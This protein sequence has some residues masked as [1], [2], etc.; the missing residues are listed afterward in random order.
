MVT[1]SGL[2]TGGKKP[3]L[4]FVNGLTELTSHEVQFCYHLSFPQDIDCRQQWPFFKKRAGKIVK[5]S[6]FFL[7]WRATLSQG[8]LINTFLSDGIVS[9]KNF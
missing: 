9:E 4:R 1:V 3:R 5:N 2:R 7:L 6:A 8:C